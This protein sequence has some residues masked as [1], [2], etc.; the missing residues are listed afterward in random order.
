MDFP[1]EATV[2]LNQFQDRNE[3]LKI[4]RSH[5]FELEDLGGGQVRVNGYF[6]K[7]RDTKAK[8]DQ[9]LSS[10]TRMSPN[11]FSPVPTAYS[12]AVPKNYSRRDKAP[13]ASPSSPT[14][15]SSPAPGSSHSRPASSLDW[16][17]S[18][19]RD[20]SFVIDADVF[21]YADQFKKKDINTIRT[22][23]GVEIKQQE[24]GDM[25]NVTLM[26]RNS[27]AAMGKLQSLMDDLSQS[28][29]TQEVPLKDMNPDGRVLLGKIQQNGNIDG[30]VLVCHMTDRLHL[31]GSS[32]ESYELKQRLLG[33]TGRTS[34]RSSRG[35]SSSAPPINRK[36]TE[37]AAHPNPSPGG[38][39]GYSPS[40]YQDDKREDAATG[41]GAAAAAQSR[42]RSWSLS[43]GNKDAN[44][45]DGNTREK[46]SKAPAQ[47]SPKKVL[48]NIPKD[49]K[50]VFK[51]RN[52]K[53]K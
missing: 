22:S 2:H 18:L 50:D 52:A 16:R 45:V 37:T 15:S 7:L 41:W 12:G 11:T 53:K 10:Q 40:K 34:A 28:L 3:V 14:S 47:R 19:R 39:T 33:R 9:L 6:S 46:E 13:H 31:I 5:G 24:R 44:R 23:H 8:M 4:L 29:R 32:R 38:A 25:F 42:G 35:R 43:R 26:G 1:V 21:M 51:K 30:S 27:N 36:S 49:I 48:M 17:D 20:A